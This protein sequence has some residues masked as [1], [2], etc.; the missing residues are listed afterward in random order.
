[1]KEC[2][3]Y[4]NTL[5]SVTNR[6]LQKY[7]PLPKSQLPSPSSLEFAILRPVTDMDLI[8]I[9]HDDVT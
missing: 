9:I 1:M 2:L 3:L 8:K 4:A 6:A 5:S 7:S